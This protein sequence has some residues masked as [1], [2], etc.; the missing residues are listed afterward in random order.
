MTCSS[1]LLLEHVYNGVLV[2]RGGESGDTTLDTTKKKAE[3]LTLP[4]NVDYTV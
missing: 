3:P 2:I 1:E 4:F